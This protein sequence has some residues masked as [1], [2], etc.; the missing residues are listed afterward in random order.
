M[1]AVK[2]PYNLDHWMR[3]MANILWPLGALVRERPGRTRSAF[4]ALRSLGMT[5]FVQKLSVK[6]FLCVHA[7]CKL[8]IH[9]RLKVFMG[10]MRVVRG[11]E[12]MGPADYLRGYVHHKDH[13]KSRGLDKKN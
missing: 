9:W 2:T 4:K 6:A 8:R 10:Y 1:C 7:Q 5:F 3:C 12:A 11:P 13:E